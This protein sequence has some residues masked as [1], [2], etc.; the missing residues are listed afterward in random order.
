VT[1]IDRHEPFR[2]PSAHPALTAAD[3]HVWRANLNQT[4]CVVNSLLKTLTADE[5]KRGQGY[6]FQADRDH[7][8]ACR[9][10]LRSILA[11]YLGVRAE[12]LR[13][14]YGAFGKPALRDYH[15]S[16]LRFSISH[17]YGLALFAF[18]RGIEV[19]I[20]L[21]LIRRDLDIEN[22]AR[23]SFSPQEL[24]KLHKLRNDLQTEAFYDCWTR[25]EAYAKALGKGFSL[26]LDQFEV[27]FAPGEPA[28]LMGVKN[29]KAALSTWAF[30][31]ISP[32]TGYA[33]AIVTQGT[34]RKVSFW[35]WS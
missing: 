12:R 23:H 2:L 19:G 18:T 6:H 34:A 16:Q 24:E 31:V 7:F 4:P 27:S 21:E 15:N 35:Q 1:T 5:R 13:F 29:K 25:K 22:I 30:Q 26:P 33:G 20:D 10:I 11:K 8:I 14:R 17:S 32:G 3:V 9:G 28:A